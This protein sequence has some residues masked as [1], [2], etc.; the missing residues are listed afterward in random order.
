VHLYTSMRGCIYLRWMLGISILVLSCPVLHAVRVGEFDGPIDGLQLVSPKFGWVYTGHKLLRTTD[1]QSW[2][3]MTPPG[4]PAEYLANVFFLDAQH[5]WAIAAREKSDGSGHLV[6][7]TVVT[8][9]GGNSWHRHPM[10]LDCNF[11]AESSFISDMVFVDAQQ[12]W[13]LFDVGGMFRS[14]VLFGTTDGGRSW[15]KLAS[16]SSGKLRFINRSEGWLVSSE[17]TGSPLQLR[18][19]QDGGHSWTQQTFPTPLGV[20]SDARLIFDLPTFTTRRNGALAVIFMFSEPGTS[21]HRSVVVLYR[22]EDA[23]NHWVSSREFAPIDAPLT[24]PIISDGHVIWAGMKDGRL[25]IVRDWIATASKRQMPR[26]ASPA[27]LQFADLKHGW[28]LVESGGCRGVKC[29][30]YPSRTTLLITADGGTEFIEP[31]LPGLE[32]PQPMLSPCAAK[33]APTQLDNSWR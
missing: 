27:L 15:T 19:T 30:C 29:D 3:D 18:V 23:G 33:Q 9:D 1:G 6:F 22:T 32:R 12:G 28:I 21:H 10:L 11:C 13:V 26:L 17:S 2:T 14:G 31:H 5:G 25:V 7:R 4:P 24:E 20:P 16:P 8:R